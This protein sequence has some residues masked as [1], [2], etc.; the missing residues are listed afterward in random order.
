L[1]IEENHIALLGINS[2]WMRGRHKDKKGEIDDYG[3]LAVGEP[4]VHDALEH[5]KDAHVR[6]A[7]MH[8]PFDWLMEIDRSRIEERFT[9]VGGTTGRTNGKKTRVPTKME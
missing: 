9:C 6:I 2:A 1:D 3:K 8:H 5:I 7:V 4:Q